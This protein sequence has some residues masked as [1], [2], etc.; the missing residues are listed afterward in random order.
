MKGITL[1]HAVSAINI[2]ANQIDVVN[3]LLQS[4]NKK[5]LEFEVNCEQDFEKICEEV[6]ESLMTTCKLLLNVDKK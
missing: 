4:K 3:Q 2:C 5:P 1:Y 6:F